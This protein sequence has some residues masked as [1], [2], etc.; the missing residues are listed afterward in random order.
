[1]WLVLN[2]GCG[3]TEKALDVENDTGREH[4]SKAPLVLRQRQVCENPSFNP[5]HLD[6]AADIGIRRSSGRLEPLQEYGGAGLIDWDRDGDL[7][8][9]YGFRGEDIALYLQ[10]TELEQEILPLK[11][12][13]FHWGKLWDTHTLMVATEWIYLLFPEEAQTPYFLWFEEF[14]GTFTDL[15]IFDWDADGMLDLYAG[16]SASGMQGHNR[17]LL[18]LNNGSRLLWGEWNSAQRETRD[19]VLWQN[20]EEQSSVLSLSDEGGQLINSTQVQDVELYGE[21]AVVGDVNGDALAD[22]VVFDS[23]GA[24][25]H[26]N[27]LQYEDLTTIYADSAVRGASFID[28]NNDGQEEI[29]LAPSQ[30]NILDSDLK[31]LLLD[32]VDGQ[33]V[34][35][36]IDVK[37]GAWHSVVVD[38]WNQD[39]VLD[40]LIS[41]ATSVPVLWVS[42]SCSA[43]HWLKINVPIGTSVTVTTATKTLTRWSTN[44]SGVAA[45]KESFVWFG[46]GDEE[47]VLSVDLILPDGS[48][49]EYGSFQ[50]DRVVDWNVSD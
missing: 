23:E 49:Y 2:I 26:I 35:L 4:I 46:L 29:I 22:L 15:L 48:K 28:L 39:G 34:T 25:V 27:D 12:G 37:S 18:F 5:E 43:A 8:L 1:M 41:H 45:T 30:D 47:S 20:R 36:Q 44:E 40:A 6:V 33:W 10:Q 11:A 3:S 7:D 14:L 13:S 16:M 32:N 31:P 50:A 9:I 42:Q 24:Y 21:G 38:D 17:D 19:V